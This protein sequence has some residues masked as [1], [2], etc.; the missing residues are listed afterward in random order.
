MEEIYT[1]DGGYVVTVFVPPFNVLAEAIMW[2]QRIF[3]YNGHK[4]V[5]GLCFVATTTV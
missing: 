3:I 5:E 1:K 4:Y 2:G